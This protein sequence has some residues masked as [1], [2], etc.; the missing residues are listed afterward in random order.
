MERI[1]SIDIDG[2]IGEDVVLA[3]MHEHVTAAA[4]RMDE[5]ITLLGVEPP[6]RTLSHESSPCAESCSTCC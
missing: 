3:D 1:W 2:H 4:I 5:A 6:N